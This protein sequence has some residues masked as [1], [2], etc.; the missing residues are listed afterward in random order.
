M[1]VTRLKG[2]HTPKKVLFLF[3][4]SPAE[5]DLNMQIICTLYAVKNLVKRSFESAQVQHKYYAKKFLEF[6]FQSK[7]N[8]FA[9]Y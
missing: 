6:V 3:Y 7:A 2:V 1:V 9:K 4:Q 5:A 8:Y